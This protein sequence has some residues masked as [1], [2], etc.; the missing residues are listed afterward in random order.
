VDLTPEPED[1][2]RQLE[3]YLCR[4][5][6][7][8]LIRVVGPAFEQV[9][10]WARRGVPLG[11][12]Q[13][14]IDRYFERYYAKGPRRRPVRIE[15]CEADVLDTFDEWRRALGVPLA[16]RGTGAGGEGGGGQEEANTT[17]GDAD[18][19]ARNKGTLPAH[20]ERVIARLTAARAGEARALDPELDAIVRE[21]DGMRASA[22]GLRGQAREDCLQRLGALDARLIDAAR[23]LSDEAATA[24]LE[25][26]A[27]NELAPFRDR[28][29]AHAY[30]RSRRACVDRLLRERHR[31]P[32]ITFE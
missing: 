9:C 3:S 18:P 28:M 6:E 27:D 13:R 4:K 10:G 24:A 14:G 25:R 26:E 23:R 7:G 12:A 15:F 11:V 8:H 16:A 30:E 17:A 31:L 22:K 21:L 2:C 5:N 20:L 32:I 19:G 29:L 1:Y